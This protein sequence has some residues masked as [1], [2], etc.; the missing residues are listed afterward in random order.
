MKI[1]GFLLML[2]GWGIVVTAVVL[3]RT[4]VPKTLFVL[5]GMAIEAWGFVLAARAHLPRGG[6][7]NA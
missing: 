3:L 6:S 1:A 7:R 5:A 2:A 4:S